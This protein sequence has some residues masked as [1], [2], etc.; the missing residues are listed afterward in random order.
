MYH[1]SHSRSSFS[2]KISITDAQLFSHRDPI[3]SSPPEIT[4]SRRFLCFLH[5]IRLSKNNEQA[6]THKYIYILY[7]TFLFMYFVCA[8]LRNF[9]SQNLHWY[10]WKHQVVYLRQSEFPSFPIAS[11]SIAPMELGR[12]AINIENPLQLNIVLWKDNSRKSHHV[13][14]NIS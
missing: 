8:I 1:S 9:F 12:R 14:Y 10:V 3:S 7:I 2:S 13:W 11:E 4:L 5:D 6:C